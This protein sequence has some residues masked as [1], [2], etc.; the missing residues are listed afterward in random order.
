MKIR[1]ARLDDADPL[2]SLHADTV[3]RVN[4]QDHSQE[5]ME[6]WAGKQSLDSASSRITDGEVTVT[7]DARDCIVGFTIKR[8]RAVLSGDGIRGNRPKTVARFRFAFHR[9]SINDQDDL[10]STE[11]GPRDI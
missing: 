1:K 4:A 9:S 10:P 3:R 11:I 8:G 5:P 2:L 7:V 6:A